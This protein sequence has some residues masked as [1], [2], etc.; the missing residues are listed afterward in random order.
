MKDIKVPSMYE[1]GV[2]KDKLEKLA[3]QMSED[4]IASGSPANNPRQA[5]K[6]E[7]IELYKLAYAQ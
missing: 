1:L 6:E 3:P 4:A 7:I 5:T 2:D